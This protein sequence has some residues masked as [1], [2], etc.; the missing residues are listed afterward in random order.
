MSIVD[1]TKRMRFLIFLSAI[2][3]LLDWKQCAVLL[4]FLIRLRFFNAKVP[5]L[6][7]EK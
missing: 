3:R 1:K 5:V 4:S 7:T 2:Q 6:A